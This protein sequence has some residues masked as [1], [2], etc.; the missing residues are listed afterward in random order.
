MKIEETTDR[1]S[2]KKIYEH[3]LLLTNNGLATEAKNWDSRSPWHNSMFR[4]IEDGF[5]W[6]IYLPDQAWS[7]KVEFLSS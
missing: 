1:A 6:V 7:G 2:V 4:R 3:S 5:Q